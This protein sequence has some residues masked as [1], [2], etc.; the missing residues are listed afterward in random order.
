MNIFPI[1]GKR[2]KTNHNPNCNAV[3]FAM[4]SCLSKANK[5]EFIAQCKHDS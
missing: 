2:D 3:L 5:I 1:V 4:L